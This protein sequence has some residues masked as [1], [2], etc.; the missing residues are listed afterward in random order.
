MRN[1]SWYIKNNIRN[2]PIYSILK[3]IKGENQMKS[4]DLK[5]GMVVTLRNGQTGR[6]LLQTEQGDTVRYLNSDGWDG[7]DGLNLWNNV[8]ECTGIGGDSMDIIEVKRPESLVSFK[9]N[10][11]WTRPEPPMVYTLSIDGCDPIEIPIPNHGDVMT[12]TV[13]V[14][15]PVS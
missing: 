5:T 3:P 4:S 11:I 2:W 14:K 6:I 1:E 12:V 10:T 15:E 13:T 9:L 8:L 7:W